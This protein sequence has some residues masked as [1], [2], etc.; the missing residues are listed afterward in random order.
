MYR[1]SAAV[2]LAAGLVSL[3]GAAAA[4]E[5][6]TADAAMTAAESIAQCPGCDF[7]FGKGPNESARRGLSDIGIESPEGGGY[8]ILMA[9]TGTRWARLWEGNGSTQ[10]VDRLPS[11]AVICMLED[12]W[13]NIRKGPGLNYRRVG[14]VTR[15]T[16]KKVFEARLTK[17]LGR[18]PGEAWYRISYNGN[19]AWV[20]NLRTISFGP[21]AKTAAASCEAWEQYYA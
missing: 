16:V 2:V 20:Q 14:K 6:E 9:Y 13:T 12:G 17:A 18:Q 19:P 11:K 15:P 10:N 1:T 21:Y 4:D 8:H 3:G 5:P 7:Y